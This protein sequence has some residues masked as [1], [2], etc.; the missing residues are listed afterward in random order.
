M[1]SETRVWANLASKQLTGEQQ[2]AKLVDFITAGLAAPD[3][4]ERS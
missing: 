1:A 3:L 4:Q 2:V